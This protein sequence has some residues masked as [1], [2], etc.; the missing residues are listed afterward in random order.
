MLGRSRTA[1]RTAATTPQATGGAQVKARALKAA[2]PTM[3]PA[4]S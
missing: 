3:E 4:M 2:M 1:N